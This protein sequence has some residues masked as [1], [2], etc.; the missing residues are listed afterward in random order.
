M[1]EKTQTP[2][3]TPTRTEPAIDPDPYYSPER[4]CPSQRE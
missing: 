3:K 1:P 4:L 2:T